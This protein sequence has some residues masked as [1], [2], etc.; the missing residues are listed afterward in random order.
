MPEVC[1][2][3]NCYLLRDHEIRREDLWIQGGK[4]I[5]PEPLF[6]ERGRNFDK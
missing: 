6:F 5:D 2:F 3:R 1:V 4:V